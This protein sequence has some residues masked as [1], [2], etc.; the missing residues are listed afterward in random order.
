MMKII[1][2]LSQ[3][4][5]YPKGIIGNF[6][7]SAMNLGHNK[8][9]L[10]AISKINLQDKKIV[11]DIGCG[12]GKNISNFINLNKNLIVFGIDCSKTSVE[13][14]IKTNKNLI[15]EK[16]VFISN[17]D[18]LSMDFEDEKFDLITAFNTTYFWS[19]IKR[20]FELVRRVLKPNGEFMIL[21]DGGSKQALEK[22]SK[23]INV[24][25]MLLCDEYE[26]LLKKLHFK[27]IK[28]YKHKNERTVCIVSTK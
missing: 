12:G 21:N 10:W 4:A 16:R 19:D 28:I 17:Q 11:L 24:E 7:L 18:V 2:I 5:K 8:T 9:A 25:N 26:N 20:G 27:N 1:K 13:K 14:S 23:T 3:N 6:I 15:D 22:Y